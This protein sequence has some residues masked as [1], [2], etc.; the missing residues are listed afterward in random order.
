M[1]SDSDTIP[2]PPSPTH[3]FRTEY[4]LNTVVHLITYV[5][6]SIVTCQYKPACAQRIFS[7][8]HSRPVLPPS[9]AFRSFSRQLSPLF[10]LDVSHSHGI[11]L[12]PLHTQKHG[13]RVCYLYSYVPINLN[14]PTFPHWQSPDCVA[15][16][17]WS[18]GPC[19]RFHRVYHLSQVARKC[20]RCNR[21]SGVEPPHSKM[22]V[23]RHFTSLPS[24]EALAKEGLAPVRRDHS[25]RCLCARHWLACATQ[26]TVAPAEVE[27]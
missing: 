5:L 19:S 22:S 4:P 8:S 13:G 25:H 7:G 9:F 21:K 3:P 18:A 23:R 20:H 24:C 10:T 17:F 16:A 12:F 6:T 26:H 2:I 27:L 1:T 15:S 11:H 14:A